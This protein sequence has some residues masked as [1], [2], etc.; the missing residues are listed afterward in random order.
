MSGANQTRV[1]NTSKDLLEYIHSRLIPSCKGIKA[2]DLS[3]HYT[4]IPHSKLKDNLKELVQLCYIKRRGQRRYKYLVLG[5]DRSYFVTNITLI[6]P[7]H[8]LK[9]ISSTCSSFWL[10]TYLLSLVIDCFQQT[11]AYL[12]VQTVFLFSLTCS[13]VRMRQTSYRGFSSKAKR[14]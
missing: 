6:L 7:K 4:T 3:T 8:S 10:T 11:D 9:L 2:F 14:S 13:F 12:W 5:I 1:L